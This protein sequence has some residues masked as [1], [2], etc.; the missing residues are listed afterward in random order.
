VLP[1]ELKKSYLKKMVKTK[2]LKK[3]YNLA[4]VTP[5]K[6]LGSLKNFRPFG[7]AVWRE[8]GNIYA[9]YANALFHYID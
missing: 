9:N 3:I 4:Y 6:P 7:P 2:I 8:I 5:G 1:V